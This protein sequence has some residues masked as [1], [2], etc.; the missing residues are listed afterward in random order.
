M[1]APF[2]EWDDPYSWTERLTM[3][4]KLAIQKENALFN[5]VVS[6]SASKSVMKNKQDEFCKVI[7]THATKETFRI[8]SV[9]EAKILVK[10][11]DSNEDAFNWK[12]AKGGAWMY[13]SGIDVSEEEP[14]NVAY[15]VYASEPYDYKLNVK[16][17]SGRWTHSHGGGPFVA[18]K[19]G[20]VYYLEEDK[21]LQYKRLVS[22][23]V[24]DG[25]D[26]RV[27]YEEKAVSS[28]LTLM[29]LENRALF[30]MREDAGNQQVAVIS[31]GICHWLNRQG[32]CFFP[33]GGEGSKVVYFTRIGSF[34]APW[35]LV[36]AKWIL[37]AEIVAAGLEFCSSMLRILVTKTFGIRTVWRLSEKHEPKRLYSGVFQILPHTRMP[38]WRGE[39]TTHA[40]L[41]VREPTVGEMKILC[42]DTYVHTQIP[43]HPYAHSEVGQS[44]SKDGIP[45][46]WIM[47]TK[48]A[49]TEP[50]GLMIVAYGAYGMVTSLKTV[51]WIPWIRA[52]WAIA[53]IFVRGGGDGN[54]MWADIGRLTGKT[55]AV[56]DVEACCRDLQ[57]ITGCGP[58]HTCM[59]GRS[60]GGLIV[61]NL[62]SRHP[63]GQ[64]FGAVYA[65]VPYVD[66]L[67]T[68]SNPALPLTAYEYHEFGNP[69]RGPVEFLKTLE[70]SPIHMLG[71]G[72]VP[73]VKVLCRSGFKDIQVYYYESLKWTY[74]LRGDRQDDDTKILYINKHSHYT[75]GK[76]LCLDLAQ[77]FFAINHWLL[78][79]S[80]K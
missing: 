26:R 51:R 24:L 42:T 63:S 44:V 31:G 40:F 41:H 66:L 37:N 53:L 55:Q 47:L 68:A 30:L 14:F 77:D 46:R 49:R 5:R 32:V 28:V 27:I 17:P 45:V 3:R 56:E 74:A 38:F 8:P 39:V 80:T 43:K 75:T 54:E 1:S 62:L 10:I 20:R 79:A 59:F 13:T 76:E 70:I 67:K 6:E 4:T 18:I 65:E 16:T 48:E 21:H 35:T 25:K 15:T 12:Y 78:K 29:K 69:T 19:G 33:V 60:A 7:E 64:L 73:G 58:E 71:P 9:G 57:A 22:L 34:G 50:K 2:I 72:G 36:G 52:G 61:G 11:D 23:S